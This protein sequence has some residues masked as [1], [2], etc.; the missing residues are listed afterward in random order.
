MTGTRVERSRTLAVCLAGATVTLLLVVPTV[1]GAAAST[2]S[3]LQQARD[4]LHR[5]IGRVESQ[6][7]ELGSIQSRANA[8]AAELSTAQ[9]ELDRIREELAAARRDLEAAR[10]RYGGLRARLDERARQAFIQ[11]PGSPIEFIL[12]AT[13]LADLSDRLEFVSSVT[14]TDADLANQVQNLANVLTDR[15][16]RLEALEREQRRKVVQVRAR[17]EALAER[18]AEQETIYRELAAS[19]TELKALVEELDQRLEAEERA[20]AGEA[21]GP[22]GGPGGSPG[23][24]SGGPLL[25]CPVAGPRAYG[26]DF[27]APRS[28]GRTH[29]G[30]DIFAPYDTP[31]VAPFPGRAVNATNSMGGYSVT[32]YGSQ[33][34][35]Y[36]ATCHGSASSA[37]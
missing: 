30:N 33:G 27:G 25:A 15:E 1:G 16:S 24:P 14:Q 11:G 21:L 3:E 20:A 12:G 2:R 8:V 34:F 35:A 23:G 19:R 13:S 7:V 36:N 26:D 37:R 32:V 22:G 31:I 6:G 9:G 10:R 4:R 17:Q 18:L 28:G 29:Q 5:L